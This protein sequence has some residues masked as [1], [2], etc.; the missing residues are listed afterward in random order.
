MYQKSFPK[1]SETC[2][3]QEEGESAEIIIAPSN[4]IETCE[5]A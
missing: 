3:Y 1:I 5:D 4:I 2:T